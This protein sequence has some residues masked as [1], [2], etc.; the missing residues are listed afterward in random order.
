MVELIGFA[1]SWTGCEAARLGP[2]LFQLQR[3]PRGPRFFSET[4][5]MDV[6]NY[7]FRGRAT[8]SATKT[9]AFLVWTACCSF[10]TVG[11][12]TYLTW[13]DGV[14]IQVL[15]AAGALAVA[16][17]AAFGIPFLATWAGI[18]STHERSSVEIEL[19]RAE[20]QQNVSREQGRAAAER[21]RQAKR[22]NVEE[23]L[24]EQLALGERLR[25]RLQ[26]TISDGT[27]D[28]FVQLI[29]EIDSWIDTTHAIVDADAP[30]LAQY[31]ATDTHDTAEPNWP[32]KLRDA[33]NLSHSG[34][35]D[36]HLERLKE[37]LF[38]RL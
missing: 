12:A 15:A 22:R 28:G 14:A 3:G 16:L 18:P 35:L 20:T 13:G 34:R 38:K 4:C 21:E 37:I 19:A 25:A 2:P 6:V 24:T 30:Q 27:P 32:S 29:P 7:E 8:W 1:R 5:A 11:A 31:F 23:Q 33:I 17:G 10:V 36:R 9:G 26:Q